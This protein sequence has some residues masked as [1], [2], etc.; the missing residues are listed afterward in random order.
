MA[1]YTPTHIHNPRTPSRKCW[2][3]VDREGQG[4]GGGKGA[5]A[6]ESLTIIKNIFG[7]LE[8]MCLKNTM[9]KNIAWILRWRSNHPYLCT[10]WASEGIF[11]YLEWV[12]LKH[13]IP[14]NIVWILFFFFLFPFRRTSSQR[15][16]ASKT[17]LEVTIVQPRVP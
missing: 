6:G 7:Y 2:K 8:W 13:T 1:L 10:P 11:G 15:T 16:L 4:A 14:K 17:H 9:P 5:G 12:C 3:E